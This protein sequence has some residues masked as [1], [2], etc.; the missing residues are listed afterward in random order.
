MT[1]SG[2]IEVALPYGQG[3]TGQPSL[4][5]VCMAATRRTLPSEQRERA[6][7]A[8]RAGQVLGQRSRV[9]FR[10]NAPRAV[11][12]VPDPARRPPP[13][14]RP[15][16]ASPAL[17]RL[18]RRRPRFARPPWRLNETRDMATAPE[19]D[20]R[21]AVRL[22]RDGLVADL[23]NRSPGTRHRRPA[24]RQPGRDY[25]IRRTER[26]RVA[27]QTIRHRMRLYRRGGLDALHPPGAPRPRSMWLPTSSRE[28]SLLPKQQ[29]FV[30][31]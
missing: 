26:T 22:F 20:T 5:A 14:R 6:P 9:D 2:L 12:A 24:A 21:H 3:S 17:R 11:A 31:Q 16:P 25:N 19:H 4:S 27:A 1:S 10:A 23:V 8:L 28:S 15:R 13:D 18:R 7:Q 29:P 30:T